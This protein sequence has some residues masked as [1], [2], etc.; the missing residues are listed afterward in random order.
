MKVTVKRK[1]NA[2]TFHRQLHG[3]VSVKKPNIC[4]AN[5]HMYHAVGRTQVIPRRTKRGA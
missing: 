3:A 4:N 1:K 5:Q 2:G